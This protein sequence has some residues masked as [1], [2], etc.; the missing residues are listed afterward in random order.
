M[1][2]VGEAFPM[3]YL[4]CTVTEIEPEANQIQIEAA[5]VVYTIKVEG[6]FSE[7]SNE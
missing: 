6:S 7:F 2:S 5:G 4:S 3:A 1:L